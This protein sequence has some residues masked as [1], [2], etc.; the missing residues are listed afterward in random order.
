MR[1]ES[2]RGRNDAG[3]LTWEE[4]RGVRIPN[5]GGV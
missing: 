3:F 4:S 2:R 1:E 5:D